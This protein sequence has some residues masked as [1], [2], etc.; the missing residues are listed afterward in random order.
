MSY[1][2][3]LPEEYGCGALARVSAPELQPCY[4]IVD[5]LPPCATLHHPTR[6]VKL[7]HRL[8]LCAADNETHEA[9]TQHRMR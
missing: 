2:Q 3:G 8:S 1:A 9:Q 5:T 4:S 6:V 7:M